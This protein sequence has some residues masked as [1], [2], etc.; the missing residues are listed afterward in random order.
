[1]TGSGSNSGSSAVSFPGAYASNDPGIQISIYGSTGQPNNGGR[2]YPIPG[3]PVLTCS[4]GSSG[5]STNPPPTTF[6]TKTTAAPS[7]PTP[8]TG[9]GSVPLYGQC[10]GQGWTGATAC[11]SGTCKASNEWYSKLRRAPRTSTLGLGLAA[12]K[13]T[14]QCLP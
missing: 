9:T 10:G 6:T 3:P 1:M 5:G 14:G 12:N 2:A 4:G 13:N 7:A 8:G 11:A